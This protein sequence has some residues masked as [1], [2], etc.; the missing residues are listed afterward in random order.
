MK[1]ALSVIL[2]LIGIFIL[3]FWLSG[4]HGEIRFRYHMLQDWVLLLLVLICFGI[5]IYI[6]LKS[7]I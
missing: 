7:L 3:L 4:M 5:P 1:I 6:F 2:L